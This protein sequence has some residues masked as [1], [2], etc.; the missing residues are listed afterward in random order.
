MLDSFHLADTGYAGDHQFV[1]TIALHS[2]FAEEQ[3]N[4]VIIS[5][6]TFF[7]LWHLSHGNKVGL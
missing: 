6:T 3:V 5:L 2:P 4:L 7:T 1:Q